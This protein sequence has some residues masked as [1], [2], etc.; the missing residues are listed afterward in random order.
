MSEQLIRYDAMISAIAECHRVDEV[1]DFRDKALALELYAQQ[2]R[3]LEAERKAA[4]VRLRAERRVGQ[5][6]KEGKANGTIS[7]RGDATSQ[8]SKSTMADLNITKDQS[9]RWQAI[10]EVSE[11]EFE[12]ALRDPDRKPTTSSLVDKINKAMQPPRLNDEALWLW[13]RM[14]DFERDG[15]LD[16]EPAFLFSEMTPPMQTDIKRLCGPLIEFFQSLREVSK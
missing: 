7:V 9:S 14:L 8:A 3:N 2:A 11:E 16:A 6:L 4:E 15:Y 13:G 12:E 1:K 5:L 10:A